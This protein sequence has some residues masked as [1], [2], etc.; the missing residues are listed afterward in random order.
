M[1]AKPDEE[2]K[3]NADE[4]S[5]SEADASDFNPKFMSLALEQAQ[6][7]K[8]ANEV[9]VGCV[10]VEKNSKVIASA[11]NQTNVTGNATE[12]CEMVCIGDLA[13]KHKIYTLA[14]CYLYVTVE[15]CIMCA[16][17]LR[18]MNVHKVFY[19]CANTKFGGNGSVY[20][21]HK[22]NAL[23]L[24]AD[25]KSSGYASIRVGGEFEQSAIKILKTFYEGG[26]QQL[27]SEQRARKRRKTQHAHSK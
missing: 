5:E 13:A 26:N 21:L 23:G 9:P 16:S 27:P 19:G 18:I 20:A 22:S 8:Q 1:L 24:P 2:S 25:C 4:T 3:E 6:M 7:G 14:N 11:H 10:I 17:A 12:H 15:P